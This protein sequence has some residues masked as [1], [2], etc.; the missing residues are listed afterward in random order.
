M[1]VADGVGGAAHINGKKGSIDTAHL[2]LS[3][4]NQITGIYTNLP[5]K[6]LSSNLQLAGRHSYYHTTKDDDCCGFLD[7]YCYVSGT[8]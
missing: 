6:K 3:A 4:N 7:P 8:N 5:F 2:E 1:D